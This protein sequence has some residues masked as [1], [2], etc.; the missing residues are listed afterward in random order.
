MTGIR[1]FGQAALHAENE[2]NSCKNAHGNIDAPALQA[3]QGG[4][5]DSRALCHSRSGNAPA[6]S[7]IGN[8]STKFF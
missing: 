5:T 6:L 2:Q 7:G 3:H 8:I 4:A 1:Q